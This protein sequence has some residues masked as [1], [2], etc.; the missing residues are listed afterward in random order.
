MAMQKQVAAVGF[1]PDLLTF[2]PIQLYNYSF[3]LK[4]MPTEK[5]CAA[6]GSRLRMYIFKQEGLLSLAS[7]EWHPLLSDNNFSRP[8]DSK[9]KY[10]SPSALTG[11]KGG[12][13]CLFFFSPVIVHGRLNLNYLV[14][15]GI[16]KIYIIGILVVHGHN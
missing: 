5:S 10:I 16:I 7:N 3:Y 6:S 2:H 11:S 4:N 15:K 12:L 1:K 8:P 13:A 9:A 14:V